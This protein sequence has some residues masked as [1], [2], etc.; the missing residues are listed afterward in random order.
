[1]DHEEE[2]FEKSRKGM[3]WAQ[4]HYKE[5][6]IICGIRNTTINN[7]YRIMKML[8]K[9]EL[10]DLSNMMATRFYQ[11]LLDDNLDKYMENDDEENE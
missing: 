1:M 7:V 9:A 8:M 2:V 5:W 10:Y 11:F 4:E 3:Q 6:E